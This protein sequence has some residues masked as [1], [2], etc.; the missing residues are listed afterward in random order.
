MNPQ[1]ISPES[2]KPKIWVPGYFF[3]QI[4]CFCLS[5]ESIRLQPEIA[6]SML[7]LRAKSGDFSL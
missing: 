3:Q 4:L 7:S 1:G 6:D 5:G 2:L